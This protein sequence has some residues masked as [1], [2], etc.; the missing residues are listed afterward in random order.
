MSTDDPDYCFLCYISQSKHKATNNKNYQSLIRY[1]NENYH[2]VAPKVLVREAQTYYNNYLRVHLRDKKVWR[3]EIIFK[4]IDEHAPSPQIMYEDSLRTY[5]HVMR[6]IR[7]N[8]LFTNEKN[9]NRK[10]INMH[11]F[12]TF[13]KAEKQR[14]ALLNKVKEYRSTALL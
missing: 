14:N 12:D 11:G 5:N 9:T 6:V 3:K 8:C 13:V 7:D 10:G 2:L 1:L 4:H